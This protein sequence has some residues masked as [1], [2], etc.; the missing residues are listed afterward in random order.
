MSNTQTIP[1]FPIGSTLPTPRPGWFIALGIVFILLGMLAWIDAVTATL[2]STIVIGLLLLLAGVVQLAHA[3]AHRGT[4]ARAA[5][6]PGLIGLL[7]MFGGITIIEEPVTGSVLITAFLAGCL[8]IAGIVRIVWA[9][10]HRRLGGWSGLLLSGIVALGIGI[11]VYVSLPW[12]GLWLLGTVVA[13][14]LIIGGLALLMFGLRLRRPPASQN[15]I[16]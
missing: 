4:T 12:S 11:L 14:E 2:A 1:G 6:L 15:R 5:L 13:A 3:L 8:I 16:G 7:Y 10:G 9:T